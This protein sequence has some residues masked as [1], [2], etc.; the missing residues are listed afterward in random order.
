MGTPTMLWLIFFNLNCQEVEFKYFKSKLL[1]SGVQKRSHL[2]DASCKF[3]FIW[4]NKNIMKI[5]INLPQLDFIIVIRKKFHPFS[6]S[7]LGSI[8]CPKNG[9]K[10]NIIYTHSKCVLEKNENMFKLMAPPLS[11]PTWVITGVILNRKKTLVSWK[12]VKST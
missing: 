10:F 12:I 9:W 11:Q 5:T 1:R 4:D 6:L 8:A 3:W 2:R 7:L